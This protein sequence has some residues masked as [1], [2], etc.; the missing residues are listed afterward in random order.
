M[1]QPESDPMLKTM[2]DTIIT[3][4]EQLTAEVRDIK[5]SMVEIVRI[6]ERQAGQKEA[7]NRMSKVMDKMETRLDQS[8]A[9]VAANEVKYN[10]VAGRVTAIA[11]G[12]ATI[13]TGVIVM[14]IQYVFTK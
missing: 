1:I 4:Q 2:L 9:I 8:E 7:L 3:S 12:I 6:E 5:T 13:V 10:N 11:T 14:V